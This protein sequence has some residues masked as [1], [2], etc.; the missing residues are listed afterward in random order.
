ME[1]RR[2]H[3]SRHAV[4]AAGR[5]PCW[6]R[7]V[8]VGSHSPNGWL[9]TKRREPFLPLFV[10]DFLAS[11]G[12]WSGEEQALYLLLLAHQ[13]AVG[14]LPVEQD[15]LVR[16]SRWERRAFARCWGVVSGKF[17]ERDGRLY[18]ER[19]EEHRDHAQEVARKRASA[20][21]S[22][23]AK[24]NGKRAANAAPNGAAN[25]EILS[26]HQSINQEEDSEAKAS[27]AVAPSGPP[28][29]E[30]PDPKKALWDLGVSILGD[31]NRAL[32][33]QACKRVGETRVAEVLAQMA[34]DAKADPK[35]W[36]VAATSERPARLV[37]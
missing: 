25:V 4:F 19:L 14:S 32:I 15:K 12:E 6:A 21:A 30:P 27:G 20:G 16:L 37:V 31:K 11:T 3:F 7:V 24:T 1:H 23:A 17:T 13:W 5:V 9:V 8:L 22:G 28:G 36:F 26:R 10:G 34:A 2:H 35:A 18:N 29:Q 33:G